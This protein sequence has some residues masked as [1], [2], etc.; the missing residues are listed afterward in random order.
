MVSQKRF[1]LFS[2]HSFRRSFS[3]STLIGLACTFFPLLDLPVFWPLLL[4]YFCFL[5]Y[6][7]IKRRIQ[8]MM[9]YRYVP[10]DWKKP[11][12]GRL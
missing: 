5:A 10:F 11:L 12:P 8:H 6:L 4:V 3:K 7:M 9:K 1:S 2:P